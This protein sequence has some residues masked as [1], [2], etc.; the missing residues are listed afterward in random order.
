MT[1]ADTITKITNYLHNNNT[2]LVDV[3][4]GT[5]ICFIVKHAEPSVLDSL[6]TFNSSI[7]VRHILPS[8]KEKYHYILV[9]K[10]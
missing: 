6:P 4:V 2:Q 1:Q 7:N 10:V 9:D 5:M 3:H 8:V